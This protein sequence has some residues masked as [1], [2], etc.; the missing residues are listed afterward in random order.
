MHHAVIAV[1]EPAVTGKGYYVLCMPVYELFASCLRYFMKAV[2][3]STASSPLALISLSFFLST[4]LTADLTPPTAEVKAARYPP[5]LKT[6]SYS[7][8][9]S[10]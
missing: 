2:R 7:R 4:F 1:T 6:A 3:F 9:S 10:A 8:V 5:S